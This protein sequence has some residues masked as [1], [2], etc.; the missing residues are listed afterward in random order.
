MKVLK[1]IASAWCDLYAQRRT[2]EVNTGIEFGVRGLS[3][4][5]L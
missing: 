1:G 2:H 4:S 5:F 3:E